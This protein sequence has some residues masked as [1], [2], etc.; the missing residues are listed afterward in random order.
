MMR[1]DKLTNDRFELGL[2]AVGTA[3]RSLFVREL[4]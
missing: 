4:R 3:R 2:A 1:I